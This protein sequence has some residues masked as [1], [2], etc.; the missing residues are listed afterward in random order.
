VAWHEQR[1]DLSTFTGSSNFRLRFRLFSD[2]AVNAGGVWVDDVVV[3]RLGSAVTAA[4]GSYS[5]EATGGAGSVEARLRGPFGQVFNRAPGGSNA[6][7]SVT[8]AGGG[9][10]DAE[11]LEE[12]E[13][14]SDP[15]AGEVLEAQGRG[16]EEMEQPAVG[17]SPQPAGAH[18]AGD[19][20]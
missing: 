3:A 1:A 11:R 16:V 4:D 20:G 8:P 17:G 15:A 2:G 12:R 14:E 18:E 19:A 9:G 6:E 13:C 5:V 10:P 7:Q